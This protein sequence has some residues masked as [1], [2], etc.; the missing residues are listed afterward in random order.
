[1]S[2]V[3]T[4]TDEEFGSLTINLK[5]LKIID[6]IN[7]VKVWLMH[8][9]DPYLFANKICEIFDVFY[10]DYGVEHDFEPFDYAENLGNFKVHLKTKKSIYYI[11]FNLDDK[12][13]IIEEPTLFQ[14]EQSSES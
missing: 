9:L 3:M 8:E 6:K 10:R 4:Y 14:N 13:V 1:M 2:H 12:S 11:F 7:W 5:E